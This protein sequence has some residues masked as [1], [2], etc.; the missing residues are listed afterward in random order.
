MY[1]R[2]SARS[3]QKRKKVSNPQEFQNPAMPRLFTGDINKILP[4]PGTTR[5]LKVVRGH[6]E[7]FSAGYVDPDALRQI[8]LL[9]RAGADASIPDENSGATPLHYAAFYGELNVV[10][11]LLKTPGGVDALEM[12]GKIVSTC[13]NSDNDDDE[14][15]TASTTRATT[16]AIWTT[17]ATRN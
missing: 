2:N 16:A 12:K 3:F 5:L 15:S 8:K 13:G 11:W 10:E 17:T 1:G 14:G 7:G 4:Y 6:C 9:L